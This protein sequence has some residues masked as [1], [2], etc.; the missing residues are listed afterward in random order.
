MDGIDRSDLV[1]Q[2]FD[3]D[4]EP[5][6]EM[7]LVPGQRVL[8]TGEFGCRRLTVMA[9]HFE[10]VATSRPIATPSPDAQTW[11]DRGVGWLYGYNHEEAVACFRN[12]LACDPGCAIAWWGVALG[13]GPF[14]N[15][16]WEWFGS[17]E[18]VEATA[19]CHHAA[20]KALAASGNACDAEKA[21]IGAIAER[22]PKDHPVPPDEFARWEQNYAD[23]MREAHRRYPDDHDIAALFAEALMT[24][25][26][27]KLWDTKT[28]KP[29]RDAATLEA[30]DVVETALSKRE[31]LGLAPHAGLLHMHIHLLEMSPHPERALGSAEMLAGIAPDSGH[32]EHMPCHVY[33]LCG[34][35]HRAVDAS[36]RA[37]AADRK[38]LTHAGTDMFYTTSICHDFHMMMYAS[39]MSGRFDPALEAADDM[40]ALLT[41][42]LLGIRKPHM[43]VTL[44]GYRSTRMHV[45]VR[46]GRWTEILSEPPPPDPALFCVTTAMHHY[47][48]GVAYAALGDTAAAED[49]RRAFA[50]AMTLVPEDRLFFNNQARHILS[51]AEAMLDGEL[52]YRKGD[53]DTAFDHLREATCRDDNL[54]YTEP[55]SWMHPPRHALGALL[56]EQ[57]RIAEAETVYR[58]DLGYDDTLDRCA[59]HPDNV[60]ALHGYAECLQRLD[61]THEAAIVSRRAGEALAHADQRITASCFCRSKTVLPLSGAID[62]S[63]SEPTMHEPRGGK[64]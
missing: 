21:L 18:I 5:Q 11:F 47:G 10:V 13:S 12:A 28:G 59:R 41:P 53:V 43:A 22:F 8:T 17:T 61:K 32:L 52:A 30:L 35:Y 3:S 56:L 46:F 37:I 64:S 40:C 57:D 6:R 50:A 60:W 62:P 51:V 20:R 16:P 36:A 45:L 49:E 58:A 23:R 14:Y 7:T 54:Y 2:A 63:S 39:M 26:P 1:I 33:A 29:L 27:W 24:L 42:D 48:R 19:T 9:D 25:T 55:W 44:E 31:V 15:M 34:Q 38:Y 4:P